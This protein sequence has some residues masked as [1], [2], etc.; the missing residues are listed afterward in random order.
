MEV[1]HSLFA[2]FARM[3]PGWAVVETNATNLKIPKVQPTYAQSYH[4]FRDMFNFDARQISLM[5]WNGSNGA[6]AHDAAYQP[7][8]A[9]R[10]TPAE[11]AMRAF[12]VSH[13]DLPLGARLWTFGDP[14]YGNDDGWRAE[15]GKLKAPGGFLDLELDSLDFVLLSP[16][17]QVIR[18][19]KIDSL[20]LGLQ[21]PTPLE[22]LQVFARTGPDAPWQAVTQALAAQSLSKVHAGLRV[23]LR[24]PAAWSAEATIAEQ[25]KIEL[26]FRDGTRRARI[27]HIALYPAAAAGR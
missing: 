20:I 18:T 7:W 12:L 4:A 14:T 8:T 2:T 23:P 17:D 10:N 9:W 27:D 21:D 25:I 3:D 1:P 22:R 15:G 16:L 19:A 11:N 5:A 13:A 6:L 24:W 26:R